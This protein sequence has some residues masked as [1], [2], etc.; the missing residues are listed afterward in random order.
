MNWGSLDNFQVSSRCA[1][2]PKAARSGLPPTGSSRWLSPSSEWTSECPASVELVDAE[3]SWDQILEQVAENAPHGFMIYWRLPDTPLMRLAGD[4]YPFIG[5]LMGN[6]AV[7]Q[8][9]VPHADRYLRSR[10]TDRDS[11]GRPTGCCPS[12]RSAQ[13]GCPR[14]HRP[15]GRGQGRRIVVSEGL[16]SAQRSSRVVTGPGAQEF[17]RSLH[18]Q[19]GR[20]G[21]HQHGGLKVSCGPR[22]EPLPFAGYRSRSTSVSPPSSQPARPDEGSAQTPPP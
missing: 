16:T 15:A 9:H 22:V 11:Q 6:H 10:K 19:A 20:A 18:A 5:Y 12:T 3:A 13:R 21:D 17:L 4:D 1:L 14:D 8:T 7:A 2:R